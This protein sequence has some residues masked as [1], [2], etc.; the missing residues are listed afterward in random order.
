MDALRVGRVGWLRVA[1]WPDLESD[2][3]ANHVARRRTAANRARGVQAARDGQPT[4]RGWVIAQALTATRPADAASGALYYL[5]NPLVLWEGAGN[6]HDDVVMC[7]PVLLAFLAWVRRWDRAVIPLLVVAALIKYVTVLLLPIAAVALW[8][9]AEGW[10]DYG[11]L[12]APP[13]SGALIAPAF[14]DA[15]IGI[16]YQCPHHRS[17]FQN[18]HSG[19]AFP[20]ERLD[21]VA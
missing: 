18:C 12:P 8:R 4:R 11:R 2:C 17:P 13:R 3:R 14:I 7:L 19:A 20:S 21:R 9:R 15:R 6:G 5:W 16:S 1:L 10:P